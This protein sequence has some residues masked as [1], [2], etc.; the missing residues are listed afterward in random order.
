MKK[1]NTVGILVVIV[2]I[3]AVVA[4]M[5]VNASAAKKVLASADTVKDQAHAV[6]SMNRCVD[7]HSIDPELPWYA[8]MPGAKPVIE[9][10]I[11]LGTRSQNMQVVLDTLKK[12]EPVSEAVLEKIDRT[13]RINS[14]PPAKYYMVHWGTA[15]TKA[16]Q[17]ALLAWTAEAREKDYG[18]NLAAKEFQQE[19][20]RPISNIPTVNAEKMKL[21]FALYNDKRLSVDD[22][23]SCASCHDLKKGGTDQLPVSVGIRDQKGPIN[24]PTVFNALYNLAQFWDGRAANLQE[25]AAGPPLNPL[26]MGYESFD[27]IVAKLNK[28]VE[29]KAQFTKLYPGEG[30][31]QNSITDAIAEFEKTLVTPNSPFDKYLKGESTA[32]S[33]IQIE[34]YNAFKRV[35]CAT[36]HAGEALGGR[37]FEYVGLF[38]DY[39]ADR[40]KG[41]TD[42]DKGR[43]NFTKKP[44]DTLRQ[45]VSNLRNIALTPPYMHDA[46]SKT[47]RDAVVMM[48]TYQ[49]KAKLSEKEID[50]VTEF[51]NALTGEYD[52]KAL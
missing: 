41:I 34:G 43:F 19:P 35:G 30:I 31:T 45:K 20:V 51:M 48:N 5:V 50:A 22:T 13:T 23:V 24:A 32:M 46:S 26:E 11:Q 18:K 27:E 17:A 28:D 29:L 44:E 38:A 36:C 49:V 47:V 52:G 9:K 8:A 37:S 21:G 3:I 10:D 15:L 25:Q 12:G 16:E 1:I 33:A 7:C 2:L 42:A 39:Y 4:Y 6:L 40:G 14:M